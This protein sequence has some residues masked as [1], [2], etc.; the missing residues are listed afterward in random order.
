MDLPPNPQLKPRPHDIKLLCA[1]TAATTP[2]D[3]VLCR[4][5]SSCSSSGGGSPLSTTSS[6]QSSSPA[7]SEWTLK[8]VDFPNLGVV[9][10]L[11]ACHVCLMQRVHSLTLL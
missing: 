6:S 10:L 4:S 11:E 2:V 3:D 9:P 5:P 8:F 1:I 7:G